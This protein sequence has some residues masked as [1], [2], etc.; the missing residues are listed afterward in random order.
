MEDLSNSHSSLIKRKGDFSSE[1]KEAEA[2]RH[3]KFTRISGEDVG[4]RFDSMVETDSKKI[5]K[6]IK[7]VDYGKNTIGYENYIRL[8]PKFFLPSF[9]V[10]I[11]NASIGTKGN[12]LIQAH[13]ILLGRCQ[14]ATSI[15]AS[16]IGDELCTSFPFLSSSFIMFPPFR[17]M[18]RYDDKIV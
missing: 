17:S 7:Q 4:I 18:H 10:F 9:F 2:E 12:P 1:G 11:T 14:H 8:I 3:P 16:V 13:L 15:L 6:R 5:A